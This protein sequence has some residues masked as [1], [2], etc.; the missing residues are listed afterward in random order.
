MQ[1][2]QGKNDFNRDLISFSDEEIKKFEFFLKQLTQ[3]NFQSLQKRFRNHIPVEIFI[4]ELSPLEILVKYLK[5][6]LDFT[7]KKISLLLNRNIK[8]VW[9]AYKSAKEKW[10]KKFEIKVSNYFIPVSIFSERKFSILEL[11]VSYLKENY[12]LENN[13][14]A[15]LLKRDNRTIWTVY[16]RLNRKRKKVIE[17]KKA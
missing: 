2:K 1:I 4:K 16:S 10:P 15:K 13:Q 5:E 6:N 9:Q 8:T 12:G 14:I 7:N 3:I 11:I 17:N